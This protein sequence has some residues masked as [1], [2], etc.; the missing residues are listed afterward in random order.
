MLMMSYPGM[1]TQR[2]L[3]EVK[4]AL[5][6]G[7][8]QYIVWC[9][10]MNNGDTQSTNTINASYLSATEEFLAICEEKGITPIL[11]TIPSTPTVYNEAKNAWVRDWAEETGGRYIDFSRAVSDEIYRPELKGTTVANAS[12]AS[13]KVNTTGYI[14][15]DSMLS[16]DAVHPAK[17]GAQA[18]F[19]QALVDFPEFMNED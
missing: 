6:H 2:G 19:L 15:Y 4:Q 17:L 9:M 12:S 1:A 11:T 10:G 8:P 5:N 7:T 14:W 16:S 18:L 13:E 3:D